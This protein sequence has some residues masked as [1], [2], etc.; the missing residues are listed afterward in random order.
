MPRATRK[1]NL[2]ACLTFHA[3]PLICAAHNQPVVYC[4]GVQLQS[5]IGR[6]HLDA[7]EFLK[8]LLFLDKLQSQ[9]MPQRVSSRAAA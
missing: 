6:S 2:P 1:V 8:E 4:V 9:G 7:D 5:H 3:S